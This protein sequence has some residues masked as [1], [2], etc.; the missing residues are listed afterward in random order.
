M[1][2]SKKTNVETKQPK[3]TAIMN[4]N[5]TKHILWNERRRFGIQ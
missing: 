2:I 1:K 5:N 4:L 3:Q